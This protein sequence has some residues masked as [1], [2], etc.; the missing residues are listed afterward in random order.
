MRS[1]S[2]ST[3]RNKLSGSKLVFGGGG[4]G[5]CILWLCGS[6]VKLRDGGW[7]GGGIV[8]VFRW[9]A[10]WTVDWRDGALSAD[11]CRT[12]AGAGVTE[13]PR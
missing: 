6:L 13:L 7:L 1:S 3:G 2:S 12:A 8:V 4:E 5:L 10:T 9:T 11:T